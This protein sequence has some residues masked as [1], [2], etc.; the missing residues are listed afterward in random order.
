MLSTPDANLL[1]YVR[2][3]QACDEGIEL[4]PYVRGNSD[5]TLMAKLWCMM[6]EENAL[7]RVFYQPMREDEQRDIE[8]L[9]KHMEAALLFCVVQGQELVGAVWFTNIWPWRADISLCYRKMLHGPVAARVT[10]RLCMALFLYHGWEHIWGVTP[11]R[12]ALAHGLSIGFTYQATLPKF[13]QRGTR[14]L[15]MHIA[16]LDKETLCHQYRELSD[17]AST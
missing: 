10:K 16:R 7:D 8:M 3:L 2:L 17:L 11:W 14:W 5:P 12:S 15:P 9:I 1:D 13:I 6:Y 4:V